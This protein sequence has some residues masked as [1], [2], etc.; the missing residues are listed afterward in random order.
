M[1]YAVSQLVNI[2]L[3][4]S[5]IRRAVGLKIKSKYK[6]HYN[7]KNFWNIDKLWC[8]FSVLKA[9]TWIY[10]NSIFITKK[11]LPNVLAFLIS[12]NTCH[13]ISW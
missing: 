4:V 3:F 8:I 2:R 13:I 10:M 11:H 6:L 12:R 1:V 9:H 7:E 5:D